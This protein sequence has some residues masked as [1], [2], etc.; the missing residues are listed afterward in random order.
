MPTT[1]TSTS[2]TMRTLQ[3]HPEALGIN[4][5]TFGY[6]S[7]IEAIIDLCASRGLGALTPW[8][9]ELEGRNLSAIARRIRE[10]GMTVPA[11]CRSEYL[12]PDSETDR[13]KA[14]DANRR[15]L[16]MAAELGAASLVM[17]VGG[18][19]ENSRDLDR[20]RARALEGLDQI[21]PHA[22]SV[23]VSLALEPLHPMT[24]A[25]RS[26]LN[27]LAQ[28]T[29]WCATL[30]PDR[31]GGVGVAVDVYHVWWDPALPESVARAGALGRLIGFHVSDWL[32]DTRDLVLDRGMMGDGV[33]DLRGLRALAEQHGFSG[34][35]E[36]EIF[37]AA[38]WWKT[39]EAVTLDT[40]LT[41]LRSVC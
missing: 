18:L 39:P 4:T 11:L 8:A 31:R 22:R 38:R 21:L 17:V 13:R 5:A 10:A 40:C 3:E 20:A 32:A 19:A 16:D 2:I 28:A 7:P 37:S 35:V 12:T 14:V 1:P 33:I 30:D 41:R 26:C 36:V 27:T 23:G 24:T 15:L 6:R 9:R 34:C 29:D 25:D